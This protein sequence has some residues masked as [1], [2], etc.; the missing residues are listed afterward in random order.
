MKTYAGL[1]CGS[2]RSIDKKLYDNNSIRPGFMSKYKI[3]ESR[4]HFEYGNIIDELIQNNKRTDTF[5]L[6]QEDVLTILRFA[7]IPMGEAMG[8]IKAI[9]KKDLN[10]INSYKDKFKDGLS[11]KNIEE[12]QID[13]IWQ[14]IEDNASYSFN[15]SHSL[16]VAIDGLYNAY[17][18]SHYPL[19]FYTACLNHYLDKNNKIRISELIAEAESVY[20]I[21]F[22]DCI[23]GQDNREYK[24]DKID[25]IITT[26]IAGVKNI[27]EN[28]AEILSTLDIPKNISK[29][30]IKDRFKIFIDKIILSK[31]NKTHI[32][33]LIKIGY[34]QEFG[35]QRELIALYFLNEAFGGKQLAIS[36]ADNKILSLKE[37]LLAQDINIDDKDIILNMLNNYSEKKTP[38]TIYLNQN[39]VLELALNNV[40]NTEYDDIIRIKNELEF[41]GGSKL[42]KI[43]EKIIIKVTFI[44]KKGQWIRC[45]SLLTNIER[46]LNIVD[47]DIDYELILDKYYIIEDI[48][49]KISRDKIEK[50]YAFGYCIRLL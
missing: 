41:T 30:S 33:T 29:L 36:R 11:Y 48:V 47:L 44:S 8:V 21:S 49:S 10:K 4:E 9:S 25:N 14:I 39:M 13:N 6:F 37:T 42:A 18:K 3:F 12:A 32:M 35:T 46:W 50:F 26:S 31:L 7:E 45:V 43:C 40:E 34:F 2:V 27:S 17:L 38:K 23:C 28:T 5:I 19:E 15:S 22:P 1:A 20:N 16:C 24:F